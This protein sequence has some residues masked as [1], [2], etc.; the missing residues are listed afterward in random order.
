MKKLSLKKMSIAALNDAE[1]DMIKGGSGGGLF[2]SRNIGCCTCRA[3]AK[4]CRTKAL[5]KK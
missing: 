5:K 2:G 3:P 1:V 4:P